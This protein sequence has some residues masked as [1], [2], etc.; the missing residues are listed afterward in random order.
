MNFV[1]DKNRIPIKYCFLDTEYFPKLGGRFIKGSSVIV[2]YI[3]LN[4]EAER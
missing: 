4:A 2:N 1:T 3:Y